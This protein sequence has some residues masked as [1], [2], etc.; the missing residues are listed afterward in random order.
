M[1]YVSQYGVSIFREFPKISEKYKN[2]SNFQR[3][4]Q[5]PPELALSIWTNFQRNEGAMSELLSL[6]A[7]DFLCK[8]HIFNFK[9]AV[10]QPISVYNIW[11][12]S[13]KNEQN[14]KIEQ[15]F[16]NINS[17]LWSFLD[18]YEII[19]G[20]KR[21]RRPSYWSS[22]ALTSFVRPI[23]STLKVMHLGQ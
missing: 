1:L 16:K 5:W 10:Y 11:R 3:C 4:Q 8:M 15:N 12:I 19:S 23:Y 20:E 17:N 14:T 2:W 6:S 22:K 7:F 13:K 21:V 9:S 18:R